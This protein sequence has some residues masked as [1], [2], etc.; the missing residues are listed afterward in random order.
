M[1]LCKIMSFNSTKLK[2]CLWRRQFL[3]GMGVAGFGLIQVLPA[4]A[5][6]PN[7]AA[8]RQSQQLMGTLVEIQVQHRDQRLLDNAMQELWPRLQSAA[9][10]LSRYQP[11]NAI[12]EIKQLRPGVRYKADPQLFEVLKQAEDRHRSTMGLFDIRVGALSS[13]DF[14]PGQI[15]IADQFEIWQ[16]LQQLH[17]SQ[18]DLNYRDQSLMVSSQ[19]VSLDLGGIAKLAI[20]NDALV[21]L[22]DAG[23]RHILINGG[24]DVLL[25]GLNHGRPWRIAIRDPRQPSRII[26]VLELEQAVIAS[27]G[28]YERCFDFQGQHYHHIL[29]PRTGYPSSDL[30]GVSLLAADYR[31]LNGLGAAM[32]VA[33]RDLAIEIL[34]QHHGVAGLVARHNHEVWSSPSWPTLR[35]V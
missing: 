25:A 13:W 35:Q 6:V 12:H 22:Q 8:L 9:Q 17:R 20:L 21:F 31:A 23:I 15:R 19:G 10:R 2:Q 29:D 26:Q 28:D 24:G 16:Q 14:R 18:L 11:D 33:G 5:I 7:L 34:R 1:D 3:M 32:M 30:A 27:S 4:S